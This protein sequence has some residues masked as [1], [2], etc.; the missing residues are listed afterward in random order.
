MV[1]R[2]PYRDDLRDSH[3]PSP[4]KNTQ[5]EVKTLCIPTIGASSTPEG[6]AAAISLVRIQACMGLKLLRNCL[7]WRDLLSPESLVPVALGD[8][9][10]KRLVPALHGLAGGPRGSKPKGKDKAVAK[11]AGI[12]KGPAEALALCERAVELLPIEWTERTDAS[13]ALAALKVI[14]RLFAD[15]LLESQGEEA[16]GTVRGKGRARGTGAVERVV[17]LH[18]ALGDVGAAKEVAQRHGLK[19]VA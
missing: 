13:A 7:A 19:I 5:A 10:A 1:F 9:V 2:K 11:P 18:V 8:L 3:P 4:S 12:G 17:R 6:R 16:G 14:A 15:G